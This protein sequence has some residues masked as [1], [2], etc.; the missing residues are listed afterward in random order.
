MLDKA[1]KGGKGY[2]IWIFFL[3]AVIGVGFLFYLKQLSLGLG[4]TGLSRDV[5]WGLYISQFTFLVGVAASAVMLVIP[6]YLHNYKKF[7]KLLILGEFLAVAAVTMC[8][9]FI[10]VDMGQPMRVANMFLYP[11]PNSVM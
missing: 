10:V 9:T 7:G 3:F 6:F 2:W 11:T 8:M 1:L 5:S 4:I